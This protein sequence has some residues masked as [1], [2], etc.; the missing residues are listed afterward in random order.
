MALLELK[1]KSEELLLDPLQTPHAVFFLVVWG[2]NSK[3]HTCLEGTPPAPR[4]LGYTNSLIS[5]DAATSIS[6]NWINLYTSEKY[7]S[8][9]DL[10]YME[11]HP[12][13]YIE[14]QCLAAVGG[15]GCVGGSVGVCFGFCF[16]F[17]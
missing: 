14:I 1:S 11:I 15:C 16:V 13:S 6:L 12:I 2:L 17:F 4:C 7:T 9:C 10:M 8:A 3:P 5:G